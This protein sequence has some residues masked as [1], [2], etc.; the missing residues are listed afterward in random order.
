MFRHYA[1][2]VF[3]ENDHRF[4]EMRTRLTALE[5]NL[6]MDGASIDVFDMKHLYLDRDN[7]RRFVCSLK[8]LISS[9]KCNPIYMSTVL[10]IFHLLY[11]MQLK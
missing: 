2:R 5:N 7:F 11:E 1:I 3:D 6:A 9:K 4:T 10:A 8:F